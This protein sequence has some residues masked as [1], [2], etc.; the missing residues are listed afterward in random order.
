[1]KIKILI[2]NTKSETQNK[3]NTFCKK[4][5]LHTC[6]KS[7]H[8]PSVLL[9]NFTHEVSFMEYQKHDLETSLQYE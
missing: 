6:C 7:P 2:P 8:P 3:Y 9:A 4:Y 5:T 1:M